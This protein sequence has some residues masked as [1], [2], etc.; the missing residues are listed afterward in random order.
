MAKYIAIIHEK[1]KDSTHFQ[2]ADDFY[3]SKSKLAAD[4]RGNGFVV[5]D[6]LTP[7]EMKEV[8]EGTS[9]RYVSDYEKDSVSKMLRNRKLRNIVS[10]L[11][12]NFELDELIYLGKNYF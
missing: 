5:D 1:G 12:G 9:K 6:I 10:D 2:K 3:T 8:Y 11:G 7:S 4:L